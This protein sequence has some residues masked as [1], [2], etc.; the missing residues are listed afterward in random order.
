[1]KRLFYFLLL[2]ALASVAMADV[3]VTGKWS[4]SFNITRGD[5]DSKDS[6]AVLM[7]KQTGTDITGSAGPNEDEQFPIRKGTI[8][9]DKITLEVDH[10]GSTIQFALVMNAANRISGEAN[11]S[12]DGETAK[13]KVDVTRK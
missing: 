7:L 11:M 5:G 10:D 4:G 3:N 12:R 9:G 1:V 13:A 8:E 6:T 2:A